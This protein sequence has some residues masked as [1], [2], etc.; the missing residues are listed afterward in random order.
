MII[1]PVS[2]DLVQDVAVLPQSNQDF[3]PA[4]RTK[5]RLGGSGY[6]AARLFQLLHMDF[7]LA[8]GS[9]SGVYGEQVDERLKEAGLPALPKLSGVSGCTMTLRDPQGQTSAMAVPGA[10]YGFQRN[11]IPSLDS[12]DVSMLLCSG[13][14]LTGNGRE[15]VLAA[16]HAYSGDK[17][18]R[19]DL[20]SSLSAEVPWQAVFA[21]S[22]ILSL[23]A[24]E[25]WIL[26]GQKDSEVVEIAQH[27]YGLT[28]NAVLIRTDN[29][30]LLYLDGVQQFSLAVPEHVRKDS[31]GAD[32]SLAAAFAL[33]RA[34]GVQLR[35][36]VSFAAQIFAWVESSTETALPADCEQAQELLKRSIMG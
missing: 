16:L 9:G 4:G 35:S 1:G 25:A 32:D 27:L 20:Y 34:A 26:T 36:A 22:P 8:A 17:V 29:N 28:R 3:T 30:Q 23:N 13:M 24:Q 31:S 15:D 7:L 19:P 10:E 14:M 12:R 2:L 11:W 18:V 5:Q 33:A 21:C 6:S